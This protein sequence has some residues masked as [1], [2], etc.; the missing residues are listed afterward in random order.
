MVF[1]SDATLL[2]VDT[3]QLRLDAGLCR[4]AAY[5]TV[6]QILHG[7]EEVQALSGAQFALLHRR[8]VQGV[9]DLL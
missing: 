3:L 7:P 6:V 5:R 9:Q 2:I 4:C 1:L 8:R